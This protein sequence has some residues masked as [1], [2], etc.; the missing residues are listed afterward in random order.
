[1]RPKVAHASCLAGFAS[2]ST[3]G[4]QSLERRFQGRDDRTDRVRVGHQLQAREH[5]VDET[6]AE[7]DGG[8]RLAAGRVAE[9]RHAGVGRLGRQPAAGRHRHQRQLAPQ[10]LAEAGERLRRLAGVARGDDQRPRPCSRRQAVVAMDDER[11]PQPLPRRGG[12][13]LGADRRAAHR[14]HDDRVHVPESVIRREGGRDLAGLGQLARHLGDLAE[15]V[16]GVDPPQRGR[17]VEGHRV[18]EQRRAAVVALLGGIGTA[19]LLVGVLVAEEVAGV[20]QLAAAARGCS[21]AAMR[22]PSASS[23]VT[24][25]GDRAS[26]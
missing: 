17:I 26:T 4:A 25:S 21:A 22:R 15:H 12:D 8:A 23:A 18:L 10:R 19:G 2:V 16:V 5:L 1:M 13:Q 9:D 6:D 7:A 24:S 20:H 14:Q 3:D 11:D